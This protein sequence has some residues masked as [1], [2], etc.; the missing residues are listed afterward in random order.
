[1]AIFMITENDSEYLS[2][3]FEGLLLLSSKNLNTK[4]RSV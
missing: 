2:R 3:S 4:N 1:M